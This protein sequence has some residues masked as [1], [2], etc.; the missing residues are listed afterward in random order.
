MEKVRIIKV[1]LASPSDVEKERDYVVRIIAEVNR[2]VALKQGL[3]LQLISSERASPGF[4]KDGQAILMDK[5]APNMKIF[6]LFLGVMWSRIGKRTPRAIS[7]TVEEFRR[8]ERSFRKHVKPDI[9]FFFR[10]APIPATDQEQ[11]DQKSAV[12]KFKKE[13]QTKSLMKEYKTHIEFREKLREYLIDLVLHLSQRH[14]P[15]WK[16][17]PTSKTPAYTNRAKAPAA[18]RP[19]R[20]T[21]RAN[22]EVT[23][24]SSLTAGIVR[25]VTNRAM[26][27]DR[28]YPL[29]GAKVQSDRSVAL[30]LAPLSIPEAAQI[31]S[32]QPDTFHRS[33]E[34]I[35]AYEHEA[36]IMQVQSV[37]SETTA[38]K[39]TV[40]LTLN[41][42]Q[43]HQT[44]V[45][46]N[47][48]YQNYEPEDITL[49]RTRLVLLNE[50]LPRELAGLFPAI[51]VGEAN[52]RLME[53]KQ[54][55]FPELWK[56]LNTTA[57]GFLPKAW[58]WAMFVL[59]ASDIVEEISVLEL[60]PITKKVLQVRFQ[61]RRRQVYTNREPSI[62]R[63]EGICSLDG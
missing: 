57:P 3:L 12:L 47:F 50:P 30:R 31:R 49:A 43:R 27:G 5:I 38:G 39:A 40:T 6:D 37:E 52:S 24:T 22:S 60:G 28:F 11:L 45:L 44:S 29:I 20:R 7:G 33:K 19:P 53:I 32:L 36:A 4:G 21:S 8:A 59:K 56:R 34:V 51:H 14:S 10:N 15:N 58:L 55:I 63:V 26:V 41:P 54:G 2:D 25:E 9:W 18:E 46:G 35:C 17:K 61:G 42:T 13:L 1:F 23:R 48:R 62:I 16:E